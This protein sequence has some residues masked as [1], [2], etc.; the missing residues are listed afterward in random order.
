MA[1]STSKDQPPAYTDQ[2]N[3]T[4][5]KPNISK[6]ASQLFRGISQGDYTMSQ[7]LELTFSVV[8]SCNQTFEPV[9]IAIDENYD[10]LFHDIQ[11][12]LDTP[13]TKMMKVHWEKC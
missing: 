4:P 10:D 2:D 11:H 8:V 12:T 7:Y 3:Q 5:I 13:H 9:V 6:R 1:A